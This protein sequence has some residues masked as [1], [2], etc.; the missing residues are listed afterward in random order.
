MTLNS[1]Q[2]E[3]SVEILRCTK[4]NS[5]LEAEFSLKAFFFTLMSDQMFQTKCFKPLEYELQQSGFYL[6][7][8]WY[9]CC[10]TFL[11]FLM[12]IFFLQYFFVFKFFLA[13]ENLQEKNLQFSCSFSKLMKLLVSSFTFNYFPS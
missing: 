7:L 9:L 11:F 4:N 12:Y 3:I 10:S 2:S 1:R 13:L 8:C 6:K 5:F